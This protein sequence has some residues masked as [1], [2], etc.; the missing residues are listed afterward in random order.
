MEI[1]IETER[2]IIREILPSDVMGMFEMDADPDVNW[3]VGQHSATIEESRKTIEFIREQYAL[4]GIGRWAVIE[5][6]T[7]GFVG[8]IGFK[9][10]KTVVNNHTNYID[11]GYRFQKKYWG[12]G[13]ATES[14]KAVLEYGFEH[15]RYKEVYAMTN[16]ENK[17]SRRVLEKV[18]FSFI[19]LFAYS[20]AQEN[21]W[22]K[23]GE[24]TTWYKIVNPYLN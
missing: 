9:L 1:L 3:Y 20:P 15:L 19:G 17:A 12:K 2:L 16:V 4:N 21:D 18:G 11:F 13:Y 10:M 5:K 8:W 22:Q 7:N 23:N 24:P 14:S 6:A